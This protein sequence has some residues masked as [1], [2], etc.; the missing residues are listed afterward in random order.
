M[1][2]PYMSRR[3]SN[4]DPSTPAKERSPAGC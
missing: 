3:S 4:H 2:S 1:F